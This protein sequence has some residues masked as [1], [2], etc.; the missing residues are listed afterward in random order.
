MLRSVEETDDSD[1]AVFVHGH[2]ID[3]RRLRRLR[4]PVGARNRRARRCSVALFEIRGEQFC[5]R[6]L[7]AGMQCVVE[8]MF[9][10]RFTAN[11]PPL[12][13]RTQGSRSGGVNHSP[14]L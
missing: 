3:V 1:V 4:K 6:R 2:L 9:E 12:H 7:I 13:D 5:E 14:T 11:S 8:L 10:N